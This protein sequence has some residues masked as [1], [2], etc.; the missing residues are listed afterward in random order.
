MQPHINK[1]KPLNRAEALINY[2]DPPAASPPPIPTYIWGPAT[3]GLNNRNY[4]VRDILKKKVHMGSKSK[5]KR[6]SA[7]AGVKTATININEA[8]A[9]GAAAGAAAAAAAGGAGGAGAGASAHPG[10]T[11][12][13]PGSAGSSG[14]GSNSSSSTNNINAQPAA[15]RRRRDLLAT[16]LRPPPGTPG[17]NSTATTTGRIVS[18]TFDKG[19]GFGGPNLG[20]P[21]SGNIASSFDGI[22][23]PETRLI[24]EDLSLAVGNTGAIHTANSLIRFFRVDVSGKKGKHGLKN[25]LDAST[26][27]KQV[28]TADFFYAVSCGLCIQPARADWMQ[29]A[30]SHWPGQTSSALSTHTHTYAPCA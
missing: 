21:I 1:R 3:A 15:T 11:A 12:G 27:L 26:F 13:S 28:W 22:G 9:G 23:V 6:G 19:Y 30:V 10:S 18:S 4:R 20:R 25:P 29:P 16:P 14:T 24:P 7:G 17:A 8:A 2:A 5:G